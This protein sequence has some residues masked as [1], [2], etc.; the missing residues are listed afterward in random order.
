MNRRFF[1]GIINRQELKNNRLRLNKPRKTETTCQ[2]RIRKKRKYNEI[3]A[4]CIFR[5]ACL[6]A[7]STIIFFFKQA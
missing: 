5:N 2:G 1:W 3:I 4:N 7:I 6:R